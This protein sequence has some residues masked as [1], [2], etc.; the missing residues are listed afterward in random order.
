MF[1]CIRLFR[2]FFSFFFFWFCFQGLLA[3]SGSR[4]AESQQP[5]SSD[6]EGTEGRSCLSWDRL[7]RVCQRHGTGPATGEEGRL[8]GTNYNPDVRAC[9]LKVERDRGCVCG[10]RTG[11]VTSPQYGPRRS[12]PAD[13]QKRLETSSRAGRFA[14]EIRAGVS[15]RVPATMPRRTVQEVTV[16]DVQ[17][18]RNPNKHYV[19]RLRNLFFFFLLWLLF[20]FLLLPDGGKTK[21]G[22]DYSGTQRE[23]TAGWLVRSLESPGR[24]L[25]QL[26]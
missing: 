12:D 13:E 6:G 5:S 14:A 21:R 3:S 16:Q 20:Q 2:V 10:R 26:E 17:K 25:T 4:A 22:S 24:T 18:R 11:S 23:P 15:R 7:P 9:A 19:R 1:C 8:T